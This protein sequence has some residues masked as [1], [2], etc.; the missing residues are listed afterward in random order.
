LA[1]CSHLGVI[2]ISYG[3]RLINALKILSDK[4]NSEAAQVS[5]ANG[6]AMV[7]EASFDKEVLRNVIYELEC[8]CK[9]IATMQGSEDMK[10]STWMA[11]TH[12]LSHL[13]GVVAWEDDISECHNLVIEISKMYEKYPIIEFALEYADAL[14]NEHLAELQSTNSAVTDRCIEIDGILLTLANKYGMHEAMVNAYMRGLINEITASDIDFAIDRVNDLHSIHLAI[15]TNL[16]ATRYAESLHSVAIKCDFNQAGYILNDLQI[17]HSHY[18]CNPEI[19]KSYRSVHELFWWKMHD[20]HNVHDSE[21]F[22]VGGALID[23]A[24]GNTTHY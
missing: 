7:N 12:F 14:H 17:L 19:E 18:P 20:E 2:D 22:K 4:S 6:L 10:I 23:S 15:K 8:A 5:Y 1:T 21:D 9:T 11:Y 24:N 16:S 3:K 13:S